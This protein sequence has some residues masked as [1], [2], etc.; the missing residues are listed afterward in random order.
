ME[1]TGIFYGHLGYFTVVWNILWPFHNVVA[2]WYIFPY[3]GI[4]CQEKSGNP[5]LP[6]YRTIFDSTLQHR[7]FPNSYRKLNQNPLP[8]PPK[9]SHLGL[10]HSVYL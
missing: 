1:N 9:Q 4:L 2:I 5:E 7:L 10:Y 6:S 3:L 8:Q